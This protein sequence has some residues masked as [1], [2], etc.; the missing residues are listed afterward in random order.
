MADQKRN[1]L[2]KSHCLVLE[3]IGKKW[4]TV[5]TLGPNDNVPKEIQLCISDD[6][7]S[8][9]LYSTCLAGEVLV[10]KIDAKTRA[11]KLE[12]GFIMVDKF[13]L[14]FKDEKQADNFLR[15]IEK[16]K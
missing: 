11:A 3:V 2:F 8:W 16:A 15:M 12:R 6:G 7:K 5:S 9:R 4:S 13:G 1:V 10:P 14:K